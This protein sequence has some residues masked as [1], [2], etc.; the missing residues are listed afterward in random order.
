[1][2]QAAKIGVL[3][4]QLMQNLG[5]DDR[6]RQCRALVI[7]E[8]VVGPQ[9]AAHTRPHKIRDGV[10]EVCVDQPAW[11]QQLHLMKP[12]ILGRL[13]AELGE[14]ALKDIY[15]RRGKIAARAEQAPSGPPAWRT[16]QLDAEESKQLS[17]VLTDVADP[18][19][20]RELERLLEKQARL[21]KAQQQK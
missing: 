14:D 9:I 6:L 19:L 20:R 4:D 15:L 8:T 21:N 2:R 11:M 7:W 3:L 18:G 12:Q 5:L 1:M 16:V 13:N 17:A 10:M